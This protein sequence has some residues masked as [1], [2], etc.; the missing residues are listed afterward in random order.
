VQG[1]SVDSLVED[2]IFLWGPANDARL[3]ES[4][5][6]LARVE[7]TVSLNAQVETRIITGQT[8]S[9]F[10]CWQNLAQNCLVRLGGVSDQGVN[11]RH[12]PTSET[13][14]TDVKRLTR[15]LIITDEALSISF[16]SIVALQPKINGSNHYATAACQNVQAQWN[17]RVEAL[18]H[19][20]VQLETRCL[21]DDD[22]ALSVSQGD[23]AWA[24]TSWE[25]ANRARARP[26]KKIKSSR[27]ATTDRVGPACERDQVA[28]QERLHATAIAALTDRGG[29]V[30]TPWVDPLP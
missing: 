28:A 2:A 18:L 21:G 24:W 15:P 11:Q 27:E 14:A 7:S 29:H 12:R 20:N 4:Y 23:E 19:P 26:P 5:R 9:I 30:G 13:N 17:V 6:T 25:I 22:L 1:W 8:S 10:R 16:K 3:T